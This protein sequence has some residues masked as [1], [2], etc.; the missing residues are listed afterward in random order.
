MSDY[1]IG[2]EEEYQLVDPETGDL[3]SRARTIL[4][5]DW[6]GEIRQEIQESTIEIGTRICHSS[7]EV[8]QE[9]KRLR[10]QTATVAESQGLVIIAAGLHPTSLWQTQTLTEGE[11]YARMARVYGRTVK[12]EHI[13]GMHV[14]VAVPKLADCIRVLNAVRFYIPHLLAL[15]CSSP[16]Y[17]SADTGYD[18]FRMILWRRWPYSGVPPFFRSHAEYRAYLALLLRAGAI[19]DRRNIYWSIRP[20][21]TYPT[22]E[23]RVTDICP[24]VEDATAIAALTR[25]IVAG[26]AEE[27][28][29]RDP[30]PRTSTDLTHS[31]LAGNEW[32][33]ARFGLATTLVDP[34]A[35]AGSTPIRIAIQ[36]LVDRLA[37]VAEA[38]GDGH[39]LDQIS[40][41]LDR[42]NGADRMRRTFEQAGE[43]PPLIAWLAAETLLGTGLDRRAEQRMPGIYNDRQ[44]LD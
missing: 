34:T 12:D 43:F 31:L 14:H 33:T 10:F 24:R 17:E 44:S 1:T 30:W 19:G 13:F 32:R 9:L 25:A 5:A 7:A 27:V 18:S 11:R 41:I 39:A 4:H 35:K 26:A 22:L 6:S 23:F 3:Q 2:V 29:E 8:R 40:T 28:L 37:P 15:S 36:R 38:H 21:P 20:H 16:Y 42:G